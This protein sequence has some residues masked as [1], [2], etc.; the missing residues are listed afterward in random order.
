MTKTWFIYLHENDV[1][2]HMCSNNS[3]LGW[4]GVLKDLRYIICKIKFKNEENWKT[5]LNLMITEFIHVRHEKLVYTG[6][7]LVFSLMKRFLSWFCYYLHCDYLFLLL[8]WFL[9]TIFLKLLGT[10]FFDIRGIP[11]QSF[12]FVIVIFMFLYLLN[13][14]TTSGGLNF[15]YTLLKYFFK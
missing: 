7:M 5:L 9:D 8:I 3:V 15:P 11:F 13:Q 4:A 10:A 12:N 14:F 1:S 2:N 6:K